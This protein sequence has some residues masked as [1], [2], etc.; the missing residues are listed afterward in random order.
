MGEGG[1]S[2]VCCCKV[3]RLFPHIEG[4]AQDLRRGLIRR[5]QPCVQTAVLP[6]RERVC[7]FLD[8]QKPGRESPIGWW[9]GAG[10]GSWRNVPVLCLG[11]LQLS[12]ERMFSSFSPLHGFPGKISYNLIYLNEIFFPWNFTFLKKQI[13]KLIQFLKKYTLTNTRNGKHFSYF[14]L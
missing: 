14:V 8:T 10:E 6:S 1:E 4:L 11:G 12:W 7:V 5:C 2:S 13:L 3:Q 9:H